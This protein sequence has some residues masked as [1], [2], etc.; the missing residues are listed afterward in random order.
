MSK[1]N[2]H[3]TMVTNPSIENIE[4]HSCHALNTLLT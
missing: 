1:Q 4:Y 2:C 3:L